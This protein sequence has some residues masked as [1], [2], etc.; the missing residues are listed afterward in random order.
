MRET[1]VGGK[2]MGIKF[3]RRGEGD[4]WAG[5]C[6]RF[7]GEGRRV[8]GIATSGSLKESGINR[9]LRSSRREEM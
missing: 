2:E 8:G 4:E 7:D 6:E 1:R 5:E 3:E 9:Q